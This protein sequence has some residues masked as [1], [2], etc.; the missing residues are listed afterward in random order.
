MRL[1]E[2]TATHHVIALRRG[3]LLRQI[4]PV[5]SR[6]AKF[7]HLLADGKISPDD[8]DLFT[9]C[10]DPKDVTAAIFRGAEQQGFPAHP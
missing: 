9:V 8:L 2:P 6:V 7:E 1:D 10:D 5:G 3:G 4:Q